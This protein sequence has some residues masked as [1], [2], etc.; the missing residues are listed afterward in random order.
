MPEEMGRF[1]EIAVCVGALMVA[2]ERLEEGEDS[3]E[4]VEAMEERVEEEAWRL[5]S[6]PTRAPVN[7]PPELAASEESAGRVLLEH[8]KKDGT[9]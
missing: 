1:T 5:I 9:L 8:L 4:E 2:R 7:L 6:E 3:L